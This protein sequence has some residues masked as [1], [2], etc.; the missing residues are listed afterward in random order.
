MYASVGTYML[1]HICR[2][3]STTFRG[4]SSPLW[5]LGINL[6]S[7]G[8]PGKHFYLLSHLFNLFSFYFMYINGLLAYLSIQCACSYRPKESIRS[9][10]LELQMFVGA[11][12]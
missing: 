8:L 5:V 3:Q 2:G 1:H 12:N 10:E 9:M 11:R 7:S 4:Q 6:R